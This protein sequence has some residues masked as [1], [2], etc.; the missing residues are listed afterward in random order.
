MS[1]IPYYGQPEF[2]STPCGNIKR[3][4]NMITNY[5]QML[6]HNKKFWDSFIDLKTVGWNSYSKAFNAYTMN[7]FKDQV[8]TMDEIV[9][10][11]AKLMKGNTNGK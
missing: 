10:K 8:A 9:E 6:E 7:F 5:K 1:H 4:K 11:S 2:V 3:S